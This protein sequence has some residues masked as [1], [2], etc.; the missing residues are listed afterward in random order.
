MLERLDIAEDYT[1]FHDL[2]DG[3]KAIIKLIHQNI[4]CIFVQI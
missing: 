2:P 4:A 3:L 1:F